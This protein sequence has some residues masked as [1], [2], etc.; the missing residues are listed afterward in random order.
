ML[1]SGWTGDYII[2][3]DVCENIQEE[4]AIGWRLRLL[5]CSISMQ[6]HS[7]CCAMSL[8]ACGQVIWRPWLYASKEAP[9]H[10][11][12]AVSDLW[13]SQGSS[14]LYLISECACLEARSV[15][16]ARVKLASF[17][18]TLQS[19][20][21]WEHKELLHLQIDGLWAWVPE[22]FHRVLWPGLVRGFQG[23]EASVGIETKSPLCLPAC[24]VTPSSS[25]LCWVRLGQQEAS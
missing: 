5:R 12:L 14:T 2:F 19:M 4:K 9:R 18:L 3:G 6:R 16:P 25:V 8:T 23:K 24:S 7:R 10:P 1:Y 22:V 13:D 11:T 21:P 20:V 17:F 15:C